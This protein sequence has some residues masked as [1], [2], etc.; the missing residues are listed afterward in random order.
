MKHLSRISLGFLLAG[1]LLPCLLHGLIYFSVLHIEHMPDW[2][3]ILLWPA[4]GFY[5]AADTGGGVTAGRAVFAFILSVAANALI[6]FVVGWLISFLLR[7]VRRGKSA[8]RG[9]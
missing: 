6:F 2:V 3:F 8:A 9:T 1:A 5:M 7:L 4:F